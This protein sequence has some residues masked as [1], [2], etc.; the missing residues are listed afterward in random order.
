MRLRFCSASGDTPMYLMTPPPMTFMATNMLAYVMPQN[1]QSDVRISFLSHRIVA[2][3]VPRRRVLRIP[4][5]KRS[6]ERGT[7]CPGFTDGCCVC[8]VRVG[9]RTTRKETQ[10]RKMFG[11]ELACVVC[12]IPARVG[13]DL[14]HVCVG[15]C[16]LE[17]PSR[18][19]GSGRV[20]HRRTVSFGTW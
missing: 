17:R 19:V 5:E 10:E 8:S 6:A 13:L 1:A 15:L 2:H 4:R 14:A 12:R 9:T 16:T 3:K 11:D 7:C 18:D 20:P